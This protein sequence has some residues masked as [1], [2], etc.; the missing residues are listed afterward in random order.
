[1]DLS[2]LNAPAEEEVIA[3]PLDE[4]REWERRFRDAR[5][6]RRE[7]Q[8]E[9]DEAKEVLTDYLGDAEFGSV[10]G[11]IT[12]RYRSMTVRR[13][14]KKKFAKDYPDLVDKYTEANDE[15]RMEVI[16]DDE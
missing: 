1:M 13:F 6:R 16:E 7:A 14:N 10:A 9:E 12:L 3:L 15:R 11:K 5:Q 2:P 4:I 8:E